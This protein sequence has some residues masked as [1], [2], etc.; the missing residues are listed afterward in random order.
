VGRVTLRMVLSM[1]STIRL[2][3]STSSAHQRRW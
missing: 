2:R 3:H 1:A